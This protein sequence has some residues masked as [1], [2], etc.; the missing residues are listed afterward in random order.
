MSDDRWGPVNQPLALIARAD[1]ECLPERHVPVWCA[2]KEKSVRLVEVM[3]VAVGGYP[4]Q[5]D[6]IPGR[7]D[8]IVELDASRRRAR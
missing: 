1:M 6:P 7:D 4:M 5:H 2:A 8:V 3:L